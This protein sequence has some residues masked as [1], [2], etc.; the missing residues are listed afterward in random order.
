MLFIIHPLG[1]QDFCLKSIFIK[2][3]NDGLFSQNWQNHK[4][5]PLGFEYH[6]LTNDT[7]LP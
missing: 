1:F 7:I 3:N 5:H 2:A 6:P 4:N